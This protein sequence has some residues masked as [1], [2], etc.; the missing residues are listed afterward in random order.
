MASGGETGEPRHDPH[1]TT[2]D[3][4]RILRQLNGAGVE[5]VLIGGFAVVIHGYERLTGDVD[6]CYARSRENVARLVE[7]LRSLHAW[8][9]EWP[10]GVPFV[11]DEQ[12]I[13]NGDTFTFTTDA[14][15]LDLVG[16]P[17]GSTGY[18]DL[19]PG[20]ESY[21]LADA[22]LVQVVGLDDLI[23]LK[24]ASGKNAHR[25]QK[26][27]HDAVVLEEIRD[28]GTAHDPPTEAGS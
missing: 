11:L 3:P 17:D 8:P 2:L 27:L 21:E 9:R 26:D 6:V 7:V 28:R 4:E 14:G 25:T 1:Q 23:R 18:A 15:D 22:L 5:Y 12:T 10:A 13:L 24:R 19:M 20:S 16:T